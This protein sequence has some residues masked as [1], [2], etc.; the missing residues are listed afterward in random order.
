M[1]VSST[2]SERLSINELIL[3]AFKR[4]GV[5][6]I[7]ARLSGANMV[8]KL[9]H[10]RMTLGLIMDALATEGFI[11]RTDGF[12]DL[13]LVPGEPYYTLPDD[14]LDVHED[15]MMVPAD[16]P[17]TK[18]TSGELVCKQV[19]LSTWSTLTVKGS[20]STRPQLYCTF[21]HGAEVSLRFWPVP[22][23][24]GTMRLRV[25]RLFGGSGDGKLSPDIERFWYDCLVWQLAYY[26]A[27]EA[28]M[29]AE[30]VALLAGIAESKK[31]QCVGFSFEHTAATIAFPCAPT[32]WSA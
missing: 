3:L 24:A 5:L 1:T 14:I 2:P 19:D 27:V 32:Q 17:D 31:K 22:S 25:T 7:E 18:H 26:F 9:E 20:I 11:A 28:T 29:P 13:P 21:R 23:D 4:A 12:H 15:A 8:P 6:P 16:S 30:K 10:G